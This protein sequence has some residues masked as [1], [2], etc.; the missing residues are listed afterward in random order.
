VNE[1]RTSVRP[2]LPPDG[3]RDTH[4]ATS[5]SG[6][7][8]PVR[9]ANAIGVIGCLEPEPAGLGQV[10]LTREMSSHAA[11]ACTTTNGS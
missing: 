10:L 1:S 11:P 6:P 5:A 3:D 7:S 4:E 2:R 9:S 8:D